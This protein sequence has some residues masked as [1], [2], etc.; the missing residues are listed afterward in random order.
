M[1]AM[2]LFSGG[3]DSTTCLAMAIERFGA[4]N[5][6]AL[7]ISY[8][9]KHTKEID[10]AN[11]ILK[12]Y[13]IQGKQLDLSK[14]FED[15]NCSLLTH[16]TDDIPEESYVKQLE[17]TNGAPVSTYVPF[18]NGLFLASAASMALSLGCQYIYYGVHS[19]DAAGNAYPDCSDDFHHA[20]YDAIYLG[21]GKQV[22]ILAPF[23]NLTKADV[24]KKGLELNVPYELTW[25][26]YEG[27]EHACGKCGTC[28]D[29]LKAF[30]ANHV[31]DPLAYETTDT[32]G[33]HI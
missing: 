32:I 21:S 31:A 5:V 33:D 2:V 9:Q 6:I 27:H 19:D 8:G 30:E 14:I 16:S 24:V 7:S 3:L 15:S 17:G 28:I 1:K 23:V 11:A 22:E 18:R 20:I 13:G 29:R 12:H 10:A 26:C 25:S 4:E